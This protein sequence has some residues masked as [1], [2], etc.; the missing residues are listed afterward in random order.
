MTTVGY[1]DK[2]PRTLIGRLF[3]VVMVSMGTV[4]YGLLTSLI[5]VEVNKMDT[6]PPPSMEGED[7]NVEIFMNNLITSLIIITKILTFTG[8]IFVDIFAS[9]LNGAGRSKVIFKDS[10]LFRETS[11]SCTVSRLRYI[12]GCRKG[13]KSVQND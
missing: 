9:H 11:W 3:S 1:G 13:R 8:A 2:I 5:Y 12:Y 4:T 6:P 7:Q 10:L